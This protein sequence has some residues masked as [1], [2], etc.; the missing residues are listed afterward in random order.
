MYQVFRIRTFRLHQAK[1]E[2][3]GA[4]RPKATC[5][6]TSNIYSPFYHSPVCVRG[7]EP[8][9]VRWCDCDQRAYAESGRTEI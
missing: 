3:S 8:D 9:P 7:C 4:F 5:R 2:T 6:L 1:A